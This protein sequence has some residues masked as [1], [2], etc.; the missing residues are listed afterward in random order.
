MDSW[1]VCE[2]D[3]D[4]VE[5]RRPRNDFDGIFEMKKEL[6]HD[7]E[8]IVFSFVEEEDYVNLVP[9]ISLLFRADSEG[10]QFL[11]RIHDNMKALEMENEQVPIVQEWHDSV[12]DLN[13][14]KISK[15]TK[16]VS[17]K[18]LVR[19]QCGMNDRYMKRLEMTKEAK[20]FARMSMKQYRMI[21][22]AGLK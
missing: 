9:A 3:A 22:F 10:N 5:I 16:L 20:N 12:P 15:I 18:D 11:K 4:F 8:P 2:D 7:F 1:E 21:G 17:M 6:G 14:K 19:K 13:Q